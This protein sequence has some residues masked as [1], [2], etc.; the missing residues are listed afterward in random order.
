LLNQ[1]I[2]QREKS[3]YSDLLLLASTASLHDSHQMSMFSLFLGFRA[4]TSRV[5]YVNTILGHDR[6][7][8]QSSFGRLR[9]ILLRL[10]CNSSSSSLRW[11]WRCHAHGSVGRIAE[12]SRGARGRGVDW[13]AA[14]GEGLGWAL[15]EGGITGPWRREDIVCSDES[16]SV[17]IDGSIL[18]AVLPS[19]L[20]KSCFRQGGR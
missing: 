2:V 12:G 17:E 7:A 14:R 3:T 18:V 20:A 10:L 8:R 1:G 5:R 16:T 15:L 4:A 6:E 13:G 11:V 9:G 19:P